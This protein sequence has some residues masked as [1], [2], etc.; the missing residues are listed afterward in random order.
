MGFKQTINKMLSLCLA[1]VIAS[2]A[3]PLQTAYAKYAGDGTGGDG[4]SSGQWRANWRDTHQG[5]RVSIV[6]ADGN[7]MLSGRKDYTAVDILFSKPPAD[8][9]GH[10]MRGN[11][12]EPFNLDG[13]TTKEIPVGMLNN[14]LNKAIDSSPIHKQKHLT[15]YT[16][17]YPREYSGMPPALTTKRGAIAG[18]GNAVKEF[19]INGKLGKYTVS[20][21][22]TISSD[23]LP[24]YKPPTNGPGSDSS[25][26]YIDTPY[27]KKTEQWLKEHYTEL[28]GI[29][30]A[31]YF[32]QY[33]IASEKGRID[34][35]KAISLSKADKL[36]QNAIHKLISSVRDT[37]TGKKA[38]ST[39]KDINLAYEGLMWTLPE[40][41]SGKV[42]YE[43]LRLNNNA[44]S[45]P[46]KRANMLYANALRV[47]NSQSYNKQTK[48]A[49]LEGE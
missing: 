9:I 3:V 48:I 8:G 15:P 40:Y 2:T 20:S 18:N 27:G 28:S 42:T 34:A 17:L 35:N 26:K 46:V 49:T 38:D 29:K 31:N 43:G 6:D 14:L 1:G 11:K 16:T 39:I 36:Y 41:Y 7:N 12:F 21:D 44:V 4:V 32:K 37:G 30:D 10:K 47:A 23:R 25:I 5:V 22:Y 24:G 45:E 13:V 19:F 33:A